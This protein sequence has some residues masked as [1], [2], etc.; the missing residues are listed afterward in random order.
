MTVLDE[1]VE[2]A[3]GSP[4][5]AETFLTKH[6][7]IAGSGLIAA[8]LLGD[9]SSVA[10]L[11]AGAPELATAKCGPRDWEPLLYVCFSR[12]PGG[13]ADTARVLLRCGADPNAAWVNAGWPDSPLSCLY[14]ATGLNNNPE[15]ARVLLDAGARPNDGESLYHSTEHADLACV[16]LLLEYGALPG[17]A[18]A[19]KHML[20][21]EDIEGVRLLL[22][23]GADPDERTPRGDAALH[24]AVWRGRGAGMVAALLD[25]GA[26]I[27]AARGDGRTA[28]ALAVRS[29]QNETAALLESRGANTDAAEVDLLLGQCSIADSGELARILA[30][31]PNPLPEECHKLLPDFA[32]SHRTA[33][34]RALLAAGV[35]VGTRGENGGTALHWA[36]W[37]GYADLVQLLLDNGASLVIRD[38][39]FHATPAR[40]CEHGRENCGEGG[41][42]YAA[43]E[44]LL[45][46]TIK[47]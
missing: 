15:L 40:W 46:S 16:R 1:F 29:G 20:D 25:A 9:A 11:L 6:P 33:S 43:V 17:P 41:G 23:A 21:R 3:L 27:D 10:N 8:L 18:N 38:T 35:P 26:D 12:R 4:N 14:G 34:V 30:G 31:A 37:K 19:L 32:G 5:R 7:E 22:A 13:K 44:R 2:A 42:D 47:I 36:C 28:Y 45:G 24:W 39:A